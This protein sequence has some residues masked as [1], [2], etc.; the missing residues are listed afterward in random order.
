MDKIGTVSENP[1]QGGPNDVP[2]TALSRTI[3]IDLREALG[4]SNIPAALQP[5]NH[6]LM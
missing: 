5:V 1:F 3:E 6:I 4:E 2:I